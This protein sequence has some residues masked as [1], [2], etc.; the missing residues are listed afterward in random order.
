MR[1]YWFIAMLAISL[2]LLT[3]CSK[4]ADTDSEFPPSISGLIIMNG[5]EYRMEDGNY[6]WERKNG[7]KTESVQ[8][9]HAS[10]YQMA[11]GMETIKVSPNQKV[12]IKIE[13]NPDLTVYLW[14]EKGREKEVKSDANQITVPSREGRYIYEALA[15]WK[16]GSI[17]YTFVVEVP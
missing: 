11:D 1:I 7:L 16:N 4:H 6:H 13:E 12:T 8:T 3:G 10:P 17:S 9:D 15:E 14:N 2:Y 5:N